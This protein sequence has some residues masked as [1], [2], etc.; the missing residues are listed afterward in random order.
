MSIYRVDRNDTQR[1]TNKYFEWKNTVK[2]IYNKHEN[3]YKQMAWL[4]KVHYRGLI[5]FDSAYRCKNAGLYYKAIYYYAQWF[6]I[7]I[8]LKIID[9]KNT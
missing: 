6:L 4:E 1:L 5:L 9:N 2:Q 3:L 7:N 8:F